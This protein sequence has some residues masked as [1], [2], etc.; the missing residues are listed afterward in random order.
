MKYIPCVMLAICL[1]A[2]KDKSVIDN[3][4]SQKEIS[5]ARDSIKSLFGE[6]CKNMDSMTNC[7]MISEYTMTAIGGDSLVSKSINDSMA[8][9][10]QQTLVNIASYGEDSTNQSYFALTKAEL[11]QKVVQEHDK[12]SK[13]MPD[14]SH[15]WSVETF[16]DTVNILSKVIAMQYTESTYLGGAHPNTFTSLLNFD[17]KTGKTILL[18]D[19]IKDEKSFLAI[20]ESEFRKNQE[21]KPE[22]SFEGYFFENGTYA[23]PLNYAISREGLELFYNPYEVASYAQGPIVFVI[24]YS[25]LG[26][27]MDLSLCQ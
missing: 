8:Y 13:E 25:V 26:N 22:D 11:M 4:I 16:V 27:V 5:F 19:L 6:G 9:Y 7:L 3:Q 10:F 17:R 18:K 20:A 21:L 2:C 23:L 14:M 12:Q 24:P 1:W 15:N